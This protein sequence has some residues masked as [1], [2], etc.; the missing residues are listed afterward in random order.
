MIWFKLKDSWD[1]FEL[2]DI[3]SGE[4]KEKF[5]HF[6]LA[7]LMLG[8]VYALPVVAFKILYLIIFTLTP[9]APT[10]AAY[11][12]TVYP[13]IGLIWILAIIYVIGKNKIIS[14]VKKIS[15]KVK[16][17]SPKPKPTTE[18]MKKT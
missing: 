17:V 16:K 5:P 6:F 2:E 13:F 12:W 3:K 7:T 10:E 18:P 11:N 9:V 8:A 1:F 14:G 4:D 15:G